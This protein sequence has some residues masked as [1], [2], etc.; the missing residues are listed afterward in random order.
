MKPRTTRGFTLIETLVALLIVTL[1]TLSIVA[2]TSAAVS[3]HGESLFASESQILSSTLNTALGDV[4]HYAAYAPEASDGDT[5]AFSNPG[6]GIL[7]GHFVEEDGRLYINPSQ[8]SDGGAATRLT[9]VST[10]AYT[11]LKVENF[12]MDYDEELGLF[13]GRYAITGRD[14][15]QLKTISFVFRP[16]NG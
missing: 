7:N 8:T 2:G 16:V 13:V 1:L 9:L 10:G 11:N 4:L 15:A 3:I 6:Y 12:F 5:T 14:G